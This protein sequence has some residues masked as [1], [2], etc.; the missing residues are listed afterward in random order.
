IQ[1]DNLGAKPAKGLDFNHLKI[2][3]LN[4]GADDLS[5]ADGAIKVKVNNGSLKDKSGFILNEL[6]GDAVYTD[7]QI[8]L[9]NFV[10]RTPNTS[11]NNSTELNFT[12]MDD[13][14][15][16]PERVRLSLNLKNTTIGLKDAGFFS[17]AIPANYRNEKI[18][19]NANVNGYLNN[20][21]IPQLQISGLKNTQIDISG[22]AK[23]LPDIN[24]TFLDLNIKK[25][26]LTKADIL[27]AVPKNSLPPSI[28]LPNVVNAK[29]V[30]K[31]SMTDFNTNLNIKT[32]MGGAVVVASMKGA[33]G[34]ESYKANISLNNFNVG[35]LLKQQATIGRV[36]VKAA[37]VGTGLDPKTINAKFNAQVLSATYNKYNYRNLAIS[38]T[39]AKQLVN[40]KGNMPDSNA[41]FNL[42][43]HINMAGKYP[44]VRAD[45]N[46]KQVD[47]QKLNFSTT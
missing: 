36:T 16:H 39:Y 5:F 14:T 30:F 22:K 31:G 21:N 20:L 19:I 35:R 12:S 40:I 34:K 47:L 27:V 23:G 1:F 33:K 24:K 38:G 18:K 3:N 15:K 29:G 25:L 8:K 42:D 7:K 9:V 4:L 2:S 44:A 17:D 11:I 37:V 45:V 32:D 28:E 26:H 13:L 43:A 10:L 46:L 41:N 6:K